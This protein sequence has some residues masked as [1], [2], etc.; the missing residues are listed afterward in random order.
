MTQSGTRDGP[1]TNP[2]GL[3][4]KYA[5]RSL[6]LP[7]ETTPRLS[8]LILG[9]ANGQTPSTRKGSAYARQRLNLA[10]TIMV[11]V[12]VLHADAGNYVIRT[13]DGVTHGPPD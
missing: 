11:C 2:P 4:T 13:A 1:R 8:V 6:L 3:R 7:A 9:P 10:T 12:V 5:C